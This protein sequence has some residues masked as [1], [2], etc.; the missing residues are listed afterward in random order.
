METAWRLTSV[1][2]D[3]TGLN[4]N[5]APEAVLRAVLGDAERA[6]ALVRQR[7]QSGAQGGS[8]AVEGVNAN[9]GGGGVVLAG[10][11]GTSFRLVVAFIER[12]RARQEIESQLVLAGAEAERPFYWRDARRRPALN[13][14][15]EINVEPLPLSGALHAP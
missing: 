5:T 3:N 7:E 12:E 14:D 1:A 6:A 15:S 9:A 10:Q 11:P 8:A 4:V 2:S 13:Q